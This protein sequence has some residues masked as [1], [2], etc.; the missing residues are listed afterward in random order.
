MSTQTPVVSKR[1][2]AAFDVYIGRGSIWGNP[3]PIG[4]NATR[5]QVIV[6]FEL[7]LLASPKLL[8]RVSELHGKRLQCFCAPEPCH[9]DVLAHYADAF[10]TTGRPPAVSAY[11]AIYGG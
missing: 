8:A 4:P 11:S 6:A 9:G 1:S 10:V 7:H 3:F 5:E 2:G